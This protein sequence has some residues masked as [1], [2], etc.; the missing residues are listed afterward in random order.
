MVFPNGRPGSHIVRSNMY[1]FTLAQSRAAIHACQW[2]EA[3]MPGA[4]IQQGII[5]TEFQD[6]DP[7]C[8]FCG[9]SGQISHSVSEDDNIEKAWY[10]SSF[11]IKVINSS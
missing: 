11:E 1:G 3:V 9:L 6:G 7:S 4:H 10:H 8:S 2:K 5:T